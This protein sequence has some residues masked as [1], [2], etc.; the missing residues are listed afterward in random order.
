MEK[1][2]SNTQN[3]AIDKKQRCKPISEMNM[4]VQNSGRERSECARSVCL[5]GHL[6]PDKLLVY[7]QRINISALDVFRFFFCIFLSLFF[8]G[9]AVCFLFLPLIVS[10]S[11]TSSFPTTRAASRW[12]GPG[13][14]LWRVLSNEE[15][16]G[17]K[18]G[19]N[20]GENAK[21]GLIVR[22]SWRNVRVPG[23]RMMI[24]SHSLI[25]MSSSVFYPLACWLSY[26]SSPAVC[27]CTFVSRA[28]WSANFITITIISLTFPCSITFTTSFYTFIKIKIFT[29]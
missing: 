3:C 26:F 24:T 14:K 18:R 16:R 4:L 7:M 22:V 12:N 28:R 20:K 29:K 6:F 19:P 13:G 23:D 11:A 2:I 1:Q 17:N 21:R 10:C 27:Y 25:R 5:F 8:P 9:F 15:A